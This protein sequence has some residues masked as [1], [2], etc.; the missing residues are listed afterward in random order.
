LD[1][2]LAT[3]RYLVGEDLSDAD[4]RLWVR[5]ARLDAGP[6]ASGMIA[7]R[8]DHYPHV[9]RWATALYDLPA[10]FASTDFRRFATPFAHLPPWQRSR[11]RE[12]LQKSERP[13]AAD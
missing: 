2:Q 8:L 4:I 5:L 6:N 1:R 9:W 11:D 10:F 3:R 7:P 12:R 13:R